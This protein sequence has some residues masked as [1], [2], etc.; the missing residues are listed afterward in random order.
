MTRE[1]NVHRMVN[2]FLDA[3]QPGIWSH[4]LD[5]NLANESAHSSR[6]RTSYITNFTSFIPAFIDNV[7]P[8]KTGFQKE[9]K[10]L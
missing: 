1:S 8:F 6:E 7:Y 3:D 10:K 9:K 2:N 4:P 5:L